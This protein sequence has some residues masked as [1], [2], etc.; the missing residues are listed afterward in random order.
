MI[1]FTHYLSSHD[2]SNLPSDTK[3]NL[4]RSL[5]NL[6]NVDPISSHEFGRSVYRR[7]DF[8]VSRLTHCLNKFLHLR[9]VK[10]YQL[11]HMGDKFLP[12]INA[13]AMRH[14]LTHLELHN[15]RIVKDGHCLQIADDRLSHVEVV[16]SL[17]CTFRVIK[18][19][20]N[21]RNLKVL[22]LSGC[23][24]LL[25]ADVKD[26]VE[27]QERLEDLHLRNCSKL[28][29]PEIKCSTLKI[30]NLERCNM[31]RG[32][33][34]IKCES[35][36]NVDL[37]NCS[38]ITN[39]E[40]EQFLKHNTKVERL[41]LEGCRGFTEIDI[42]SEI[43]RELNLG[44]CM[45]MN[46]CKIIANALTSLELGMCMKLEAL[47]LGLNTIQS[48]DLSMLTMKRLAISAKDLVKMNL[49]GCCKLENLEHFSCPKLMELDISGSSLSPKNFAVGK[50]TKLRYGGEATD[51]SDPFRRR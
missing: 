45:T 17:F 29:V 3:D 51:W 11:Q 5:P 42:K 23:R 43:L 10:L 44:M 9:A 6:L 14:T 37:S 15:V 47:N 39:G 20:T 48:L 25:D 50:K 19:F 18:S 41:Y 12:I 49:S 1:G 24:A 26:I 16:G 40:M 36:I 46:K 34:K 22:K 31:L 4:R 7:I 35:L 8:T 21:S 28:T 32:L 33:N 27:R 38:S 30:L 2:P 13:S